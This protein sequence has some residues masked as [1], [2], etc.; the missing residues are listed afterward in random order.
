MPNDETSRHVQ[1][2]SCGHE[3]P[4]LT[5]ELCPHCGS[6]QLT[7]SL[8]FSDNMEWHDNLRGK[9]K[10]PNFNSKRNPRREFRVGDSFTRKDG[11]WRDMYRLIDKDED[12]Y[13]EVITDKESG[14]VVHECREPLTEH[15]GHGTAKK[16]PPADIE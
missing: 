4:S 7:V 13:V 1:C 3:W 6:D 2:Q 12:I 10:D 14:E 16:R 9:V 11:K 5:D 8:H 15:Q